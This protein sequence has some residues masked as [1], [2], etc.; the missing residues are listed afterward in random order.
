MELY[1]TTSHVTHFYLKKGYAIKILGSPLLK[2]V[3]RGVKRC[4]PPKADSRVAF[5]LIHY[6]L[7][8]LK[9]NIAAIS[10]GFFAMFRFYSYSKFGMENLTLVL[11]GGREVT[12]LLVGYEVTLDLLTSNCVVG[13]YFIFDDKFHLG[14]RAY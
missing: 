9:K 14:A 4:M 2:A 6:Q 3:M 5:L 11:K 7:P 12:P 8:R 13:F 1:G 10:F